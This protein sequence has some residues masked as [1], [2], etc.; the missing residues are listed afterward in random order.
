V[1]MMLGTLA[2]TFTVGRNG[3]NQFVRQYYGNLPEKHKRLQLRL[4]ALSYPDSHLANQAKL[5][6][7]SD[8]WLSFGRNSDALALCQQVIDSKREK[9]PVTLATAFEQRFKFG[10]LSGQPA[11]DTSDLERAL[12]LLAG[13]QSPFLPDLDSV[14]LKHYLPHPAYL[15]ALDIGD[16]AVMRNN[17]ELGMRALNMA[18]KHRFSRDMHFS[19]R[20]LEL[21]SKLFR[22]SKDRPLNSTDHK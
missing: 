22:L 14:A 17:Y 18:E 1:V 5:S 12:G 2:V 8:L 19:G 13:A 15:L 20:I 3:L 10:G 21:Q 9:D 4:E 6:A 16:L 7:A 11:G